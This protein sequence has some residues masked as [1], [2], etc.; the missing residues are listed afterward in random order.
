MDPAGRS[1]ITVDMGWEFSARLFSV[2]CGS[3]TFLCE[4]FLDVPPMEVRKIRQLQWQI[5]VNPF[6]V[7]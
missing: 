6:L 1:V 5:K 3:G 2:F 4:S 7:H